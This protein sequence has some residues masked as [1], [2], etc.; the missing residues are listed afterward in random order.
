ML[1]IKQISI[2]QY[3][4]TLGLIGI[5]SA[6]GGGGGGDDGP[7][8]DPNVPPRNVQVVSWDGDSSEV[9]NTIS[10]KRDPAATNYRV[11]WDTSPGVTS[12][13]SVVVPADKDL[14]YITHS[15]SEVVEGITYYYRVQALSDGQTSVLSAEVSGTPQKAITGNHL[16]D[17]AWDGEDT[18][19]AVGDSGD[20]ITS[21]NGTTD[22]WSDASDPDVTENLSAVTWEGV[23]NQFL[24]VGASGKVLT[25][26]AD[27]T[28][29]EVASGVNTD[30]E[31]VAWLGD[32]YI[33]VGKHSTLLISNE[34]GS[35]WSPVDL[36]GYLAGTSLTVTDLQNITL[37]GVA[38]GDGM[39]LVV[40]TNGTVVNASYQ[41]SIDPTP[42][43]WQILPQFTNNDLNDATWDGSQFFVSGS[44]DT[45][46][47]S[48][49]GSNWDS[50][51][52]ATT[53]ITF[54]GMSQ[55]DSAL[56]LD[57]VPATAG[58]S[59]TLLVDPQGAKLN[60]PTG[61]N[62]QLASLTWIEKWVDADPDPDY[63]E[64]PP[65]FVIVGHDGTVLTIEYQH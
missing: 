49:D 37:K 2:W 15:D 25:S 20:I 4:F 35:I 47:V 28:W 23:N 41:A 7:V 62:Q 18:L 65:Y 61:T 50:I 64:F 30:L 17:V 51:N 44:N 6:C 26:N 29:N 54:V 48:S 52:T 43:G 14:N 36:S 16:N 10:W 32:R 33:A 38:F 3:F 56:P 21:P 31:D 39:I 45:L 34:D 22:V 53:T 40:G 55:W 27:L 19:I 57:L 9:S 5:L 46:L 42:T 8:F 58:S 63:L 24:I 1:R 13:S 12:S 59:G 11:Y 60:V